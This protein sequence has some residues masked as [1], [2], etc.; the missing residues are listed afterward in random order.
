MNKVRH[1]I[2]TQELSKKEIFEIFRLMKMLKE[3]R[4]CGAVPELLKNKTLAMIFEEPS[5]RTR[6]SFEAAMTLLGG[7]AQYLKPGEL[8]L[9]VRESLYDTTKVLSHMCDGIMCRALKHETVLNLAKYADVPV[10]NGLTDYNHPTQAICDVFT[11]L[12]Y[13]PATKNL[14]YEDIKFEDIKVVFIGDRTNVCSSTM[15]ITTKLGMNFVHISPQKYQSP[16]A[17]VDIAKENIKQANSGS[18]LVTDDLEQV[19]GADIIYTD[20]WWWVDQEDE[21]EERVKAF[22]PTYQVTPELMKKAGD[23]ALFMH[24]LPAS[25][26]V[27]VYDEVIDS[28]HSIAFQQAENRLTAQMGLLVYYLY[29]QIDKSSNAVKDYYR[30]KVEAFMEHQDRSW[31]QRYTYNNDYAENKNKK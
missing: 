25:R 14:E 6:V 1:F 8:H 23:Q 21:A 10:L 2:D 15:H 26:N 9:G 11:M 31:K 16:Q 22:K 12:E 27:E 3:A 18:V 30:G 19:K 28:D 13:M 24:C 17:W 29:P 7:H 4:Y 20:L 5:T